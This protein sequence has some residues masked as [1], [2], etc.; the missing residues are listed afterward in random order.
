MP[1]TTYT[2]NSTPAGPGGSPTPG[3]PAPQ[4]SGGNNDE[5]LEMLID[6]N[7]E[8]KGA[9][10]A[11][12][13]DQVIDQTISVLIGKTKPNAMLTGPPG[14]GKTKIAEEIARRIAVND[15]SIPPQLRDKTIYEL[16]LSNLVA[17]ASY[18]GELEAR[19]KA[20]V[21]FAED[22]RNKAILF[23]DEIHVIVSSRSSVYQQVAQILK[24]GLARG[25]M[26]VIGATTQQEARSFDNDPAL[27]RRFSRLIVDELTREQTIEIL[28]DVNPSY[29]AHYQHQV[30]APKDVLELV[31]IIA[32]EMS[33]A[34]SHRPDSAITLLDRSMADAVV[35]RNR[36]MRDA[37][38]AG[39]TM[40][41]NALQSQVR[42]TENRLR[43][44]AL[45]LA[46][47]HAAPA[48]V[49]LDD[50]RKQ[51]TVIKG[52]DAITEEV[53]DIIRRSQLSVFPKKTPV[54][55]MFAGPSG[56]GKTEV[57]KI[58][59][60][61]IT[62]QDPIIVNM[63]EYQAGNSVNRLIGSPDGFVGSD[64]NKEKPFDTLESNPYRL[65]LLDE[66]EKSHV[67]VQRLFLSVFDEGYMRTSQGRVIDFSKAIIIATTNA[68]REILSGRSIGFGEPA[69]LNQ[70]TLTSALAQHFEPEFLG[71]FS[72]VVGFNP[73]DQK[74]YAEILQSIYL[75]ERERIQLERPRTAALLPT[76]IDEDTLEELTA[77]TY[78]RVLGA[79]PAKRAAHR[80]LEDALIAAQT[81]QSFGITPA[82]QD[83][84]RDDDQNDD[85]VD[86]L[87]DGAALAD[88]ADDDRIVSDED[89]FAGTPSQH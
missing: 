58:I 51:L 42:L 11:K 17:G 48:Q 86:D 74:V 60:R 63:T 19:M 59:S 77:S 37:Q 89:P 66:M 57:A 7:E 83:D 55:L 28:E 31:A 44:V 85:T 35:S 14:V 6:Y 64:S 38:D 20:L 73:I 41:V 70:S 46:S 22:P 27:A 47:G 16:P 65:I 54:T 43:Q 33:S 3:M 84:T 52:Q 49:E 9:Q 67:D 24:P 76:Q 2:G 18:V 79:R 25:K 5:I 4:S 50:V 69:P 29:T 53:V 34:G 71:R 81:A 15:T 87:D 23:I 72:K 26:S 78:N 36:A 30:G 12:F 39:N 56:V 13:R 82:P 45:R 1:L 40:L 75:T 62:D 61:T 88:D 68:A 10:P 21:E 8:F 32:D 80:F